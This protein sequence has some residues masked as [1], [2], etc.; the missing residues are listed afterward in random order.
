MPE[1][2]LTWRAVVSALKAEWNDVHEWRFNKGSKFTENFMSDPIGTM[3]ENPIRTAAQASGL[4]VTAFLIAACGPDQAPTPVF[5]ATP[6][7]QPVSP[8]AIPTIIAPS[9]N[10]PTAEAKHS[11]TAESG[12]QLLGARIPDIGSG[13][14]EGQEM[15]DVSQAFLPTK[16]PGSLLREAPFAVANPESRSGNY[17]SVNGKK[18]YAPGYLDSLTVGAGQQ[19]LDYKPEYSLPGSGVV[20]YSDG[21]THWLY[22]GLT[23]VQEGFDYFVAK[24]KTGELK[25]VRLNQATGEY[26]FADLLTPIAIA[27]K[28]TLDQ[29]MNTHIGSLTLAPLNN[30]SF[31]STVAEGSLIS[32]EIDQKWVE[33]GYLPDLRNGGEITSVSKEIN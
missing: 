14:L 3:I 10:T 11:S 16:I 22:D 23:E 28:P 17:F 8:E 31:M 15:T 19:V 9:T 5:V 2:T 21:I 20:V 7:V 12:I 29:F 24:L 25:M 6:T 26:G 30:E 1:R 27:E 4:V 18:Y 32:P 33:M 13:S